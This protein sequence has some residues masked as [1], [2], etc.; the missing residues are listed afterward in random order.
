MS[1]VHLVLF[2]FQGP[3][4]SHSSKEPSKFL[5]SGEWCLEGKIWDVCVFIAIGAS[6]LLGPLSGR[7]RKHM[8]MI[9]IHVYIYIYFHIFT[10]IC[11]LTWIL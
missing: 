3:R 6:L 4:I 5:F 11:E 10:E 9:Y 1:Q 8:H 7:A 2:L